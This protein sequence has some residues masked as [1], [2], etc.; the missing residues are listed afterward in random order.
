[1]PGIT[2]QHDGGVCGASTA[3]FI[4]SIEQVSMTARAATFITAGRKAIAS[5]S[6]ERRA[7]LSMPSLS[8]DYWR[9]SEVAVLLA[10]G[11]DGLLAPGD[12]A[13][14]VAAVAAEA[15]P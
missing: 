5:N 4:V 8:F 2:L 6:R 3:S 9:R 10:E 1:M 13:L 14:L 15:G 7:L 11:F 12:L